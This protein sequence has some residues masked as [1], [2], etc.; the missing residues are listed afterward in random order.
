MIQKTRHCFRLCVFSAFRSKENTCSPYCT[1]GNSW[2]VGG[3]SEQQ[4][5]WS[6]KSFC[7]RFIAKTNERI[8]KHTIQCNVS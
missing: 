2:A 7:F 3:T 1:S 5:H 6:V 8:F 4:A